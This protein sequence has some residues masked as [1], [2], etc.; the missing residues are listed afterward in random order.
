MGFLDN[1]LPDFLKS[2]DG[3]FVKLE[4]S[5]DTVFGPGPLLI[6]YNCPAG[7]DNDEIQDMLADEAPQAFRKGV[8]LARIN[9]NDNNADTGILDE[10]MET[11]LERLIAQQA[12]QPSAST[13]VSSSSSPTLSLSPPSDTP[14]LLF[15]GF[16]NAE[17]L[18]LYNLLGGEIYQETDG[19]SSPAC[20]KVVPNALQKPL[21]QVLE[22]ICGDH[23]DAIQ[24]TAESKW[25]NT[26]QEVLIL[27]E[28]LLEDLKVFTI[29]EGNLGFELN[30]NVVTD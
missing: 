13:K 20:A 29:F 12:N 17:M 21:G 14:V 7:I 22:E 19:A 18:S 24:Q 23:R 5:A 10:P 11:A 9:D 26:P 1:L 2:R 8:A 3:D 25:T 28:T 15:S 16:A 27:S 30:E 6:L 4:E